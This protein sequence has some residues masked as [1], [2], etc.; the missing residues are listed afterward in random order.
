MKADAEDRVP[1]SARIRKST[2]Q[3]LEREA[4]KVGLSLAEVVS[5][6]L[7]D[8]AHWLNESGSRKRGK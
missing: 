6:T 7:E 2:R 8:Y 3:L 4:K 5:S 1:V